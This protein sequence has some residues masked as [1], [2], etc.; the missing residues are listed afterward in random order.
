MARSKISYGWLMVMV[1]SL[2]MVATF[3]GR[4]V[5]LGL[6][7]EPLM[8]DLG[9]TRGDFS[10]H[11]MIATLVG[12]L[13]ALLAGRL[14]DRLGLRLVLSMVL[15]LLAA[16]VMA[17]SQ[18]VTAGTI[19]VFLILT[20][21]IGQSALSTV[22]V[23]TVGK[24]FADRL[25]VAMG[26]FSVLVAIG[27]VIAIVA[28][29]AQIEA[30]GWRP[31]WF[32]IG[33]AIAVL[34]VVT[35]MV[36]RDRDGA[37]DSSGGAEEKSTTGEANSLTLPEALRTGCFWIFGI[38]MALYGGVLAAVSL[39]NE[40]ILAELG[41]GAVTFRYAMAG[42]MVGGLVGNVGAA[43][44]ARY[45]SLPR[46][47]AVSLA[48]LAI[49]ML[50]YGKLSAPWQVIAHGSLYG[51]CGGVFSVLFFTGFAKAF[52][53]EHL[54]KIQGCAQALAVVASA[55]GP[56]WLAD[57]QESCGTYFTALSIL[58]PVFAAAA[59]AAWFVRMPRAGQDRVDA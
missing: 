35:A 12:S 8:Q 56:W 19:V 40:S 50:F 3:P 4:T 29:Q 24:W 36:A 45:F 25:V 55:L 27:F 42:L 57:R 39:F 1:A 49:V 58:A 44:A 17:M 16:M 54:G 28:S 31:V 34:G 46:I 47:M 15:L 11:N 20:R 37:D 59:M 53:R 32:A 14:V 13:F 41:F 6:V 2:S 9:L 48:L 52:G 10:R 33:A 18:W 30:R 23:T 7:A 43:L 51:L 5:G 21:G 22:S 26:V 38:G